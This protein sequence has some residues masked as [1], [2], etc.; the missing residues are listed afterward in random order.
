[1]ALMSNLKLR[2]RLAA[3]RAGFSAAGA[4]LVVIGLGFLTAAAWTALSEA[5]DAL[6]ASLVLGAAYLGIGLV[7]LGLAR[8]H[9][10]DVAVARPQPVATGPTFRTYLTAALLEAFLAGL[11]AGAVRRARKKG[12]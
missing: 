1:M 5:R 12:S 11:A 7:F 2:A 9:V 3:R 6:F 4:V 10:S 8:R